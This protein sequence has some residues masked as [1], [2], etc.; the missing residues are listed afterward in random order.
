M[1]YGRRATVC[2]RLV[3]KVQGLVVVHLLQSFLKLHDL[4]ETSARWEGHG[5]HGLSG[6]AKE[7]DTNKNEKVNEP[8]NR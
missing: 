6:L 3:S 8:K 5:D 2:Y 7:L 1:T 4:G